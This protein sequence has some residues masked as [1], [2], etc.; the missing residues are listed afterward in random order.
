[1]N[2]SE[3]DEDLSDIASYLADTVQL[4]VDNVISAVSSPHFVLQLGFTIRVPKADFQVCSFFRFYLSKE[5]SILVAECECT[6][7]Y[8]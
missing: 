8:W 7:Q 5:I 1:M 3:I 2:G 4:L 6:F